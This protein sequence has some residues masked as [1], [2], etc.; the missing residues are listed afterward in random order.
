[1]SDEQYRNGIRRSFGKVVHEVDDILSPVGPVTTLCGKSLSTALSVFTAELAN[2]PECL[3]QVERFAVCRIP[4]SERSKVFPV[5][6]YKLH[7]PGKM[8]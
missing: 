3:K 6:E 8:M 5:H 1:M 2:C 4:A 7:G